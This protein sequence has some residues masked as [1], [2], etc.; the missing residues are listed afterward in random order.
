[1]EKLSFLREEGPPSLEDRAA[2]KER[3]KDP[4]KGLQ[5]RDLPGGDSEG[6]VSAG[7]GT[8]VRLTDPQPPPQSP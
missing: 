2:Q 6:E 1:M 3:W 8:V 7:T 5:H 4:G